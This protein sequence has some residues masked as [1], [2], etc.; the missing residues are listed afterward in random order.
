MNRVAGII[1]VFACVVACAASAQVTAGGGTQE[2]IGTLT[3]QLK[4]T[5]Q[6]ATGGAGAIFGLAK[7]KLAPDQFST[8]A[9]V[10]P[11]MDKLLAAAPSSST[12]TA[13]GLDAMLP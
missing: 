3:N 13:G 6:Q 8:I 4:V 2:L 9:G 7:S 12:A 11:G 10:V 5:P 1:R